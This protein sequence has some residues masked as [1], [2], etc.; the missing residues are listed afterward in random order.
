MKT[1]FPNYISDK[2]SDNGTKNIGIC[3]PSILIVSLGQ[4]SLRFRGF[5]HADLKNR[6][7]P[8]GQTGANP[9][10]KWK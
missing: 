8:P 9:L 5:C 3:P 7:V 6:G 2:N 4:L 1:N 10:L